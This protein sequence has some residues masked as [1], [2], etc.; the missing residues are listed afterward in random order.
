MAFVIIATIHDPRY[1]LQQNALCI[2]SAQVIRCPVSKFASLA[3]LLPWQSCSYSAAPS[4]VCLTWQVSESTCRALR[5]V[6][7]SLTSSNK[8]LYSVKHL[9]TSSF[10]LLV[11]VPLL[12]VRDSPFSLL[13]PLVLS[14]IDQFVRVAVTVPQIL[15]H[16][17]RRCHCISH[18]QTIIDYCY[19]C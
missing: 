19:Y 8:L 13:P 6:A 14:N 3:D 15:R 1:I 12:Q 11:V 4:T 10:L 9:A 18:N 16:S 5:V 7:R 17:L 2:L